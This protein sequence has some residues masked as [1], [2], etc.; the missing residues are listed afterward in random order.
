MKSLILCEGKTDAILISYLMC[1]KWKWKPI[2]KEERKRL[3]NYDIIASEK[4]NESVEWYVKGDDELLICGVGGNGNFKSFFLDK[5]DPIQ[6]SYKPEDVFR[7]IIVVTD[8]D[9][10]SIDDLEKKF[11]N[12][13]KDVITKMKNNTWLNNYYHL[14]GFNTE[15]EVK[16]FLLIIPSSEEGAL[17]NVLL[18]SISENEQDKI[19]VNKASK[20]VDEIKLEA[21]KFLPNQSMIMKAK[22][23]V[24]FAILSPQKVFSF[25]DEILKSVEW[26]KSDS[27]M[28]LFKEFANI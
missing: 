1:K 23:G 12:N 5:I 10:N 17:E 26:E 19:I 4:A 20:F 3:K 9:Y 25:I 28:E 16:S 27:L 11:S 8:H 13:F 14:D 15:V 2:N 21:I 6:K 24:V 22:L 7:K 18:N